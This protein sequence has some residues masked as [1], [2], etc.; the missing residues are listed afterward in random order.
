M[1]GTEMTIRLVDLD[2]KPAEPPAQ[3]LFAHTLC[4]NRRLAEQVP[5]GALLQIEEAAPAAQIICL[6]KP[7]LQLDAP[8]AGATL[9]RLISH[10]SLNHLSLS[11][12]GESLRALR[13]ILRLYSYVNDSAVTQQI[14]GIREMTCRNVVRLVGT[15]A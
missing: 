12:H 3:T 8:L 9:W 14:A 15:E 11:S 6:T 10:L 2:F 7:T 5:A 13:E 4:T 1:T